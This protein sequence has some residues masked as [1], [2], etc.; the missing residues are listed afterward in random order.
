MS[1]AVTLDT[2]ELKQLFSFDEAFPKALKIAVNRTAKWAGAQLAKS[3][4][5]SVKVQAKIVRGRVKIQLGDGVSRVWIGL[6]EIQLSRL[7]PRQ[8]SSGVT[9]GPI[10]RKGAFVVKKLGGNVFQRTGKSR[11]PIEKAPGLPI[12]DEG[13]KALSEIA[14]Q[15]PDRLVYEMKRALRWRK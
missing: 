14:D 6:D 10:R 13:Q 2:S 1:D 9:A 11:L 5:K 12:A 7:K 4:G 8:T 15:A 3:V